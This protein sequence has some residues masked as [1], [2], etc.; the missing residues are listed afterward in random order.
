ML[1]KD[2]EVPRKKSLVSVDRHWMY[3]PF[4]S[5]FET[6]EVPPRGVQSSVLFPFWNTESDARI[7]KVISL[8]DEVVSTHENM[9]TTVPGLP[10]SRTC[11]AAVPE[12]LSKLSVTVPEDETCVFV[13]TPAWKSLW[14][15][16]VHGVEINAVK[17]LFD[18]TAL[19]W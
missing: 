17:T 4:A 13:S 7:S 1:C 14:L 18:A 3:R 8:F 16:W 12:V 2:G 6:G 9:S 11:E 15:V 10:V 19:L 5:P